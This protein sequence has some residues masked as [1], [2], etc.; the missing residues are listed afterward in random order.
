MKKNQWLTVLEANKLLQSVAEVTAF[1]H[2]LEEIAKELDPV[3]LPELHLL[4]DDRCEQP[5][6]LFGLVHFLESF[7]ISS[8][9]S[10]FVS[11]APQLLITASGWVKI[12]HSRIL[13]DPES[14]V[15]Y[16]S[17]LKSINQSEPN[18]VRQLLEESLNYHLSDKSLELEVV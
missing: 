1:E 6:V 14:C 4:L 15:V 13:N 10:A 12:L 18:F 2:A 17:I 11:V 16:Q 7:E 3:L 8:Q 5:E 9:L